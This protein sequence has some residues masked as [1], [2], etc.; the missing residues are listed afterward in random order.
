MLA[1][2]NLRKSEE[3]ANQTPLTDMTAGEAQKEKVDETE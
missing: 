3:A 1:L 2:S